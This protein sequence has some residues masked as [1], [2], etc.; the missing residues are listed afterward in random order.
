MSDILPAASAS[1][2]PAAAAKGS[3]GL[4]K[5][6]SR[7]Q[8]EDQRTCLWP[9]RHKARVCKV[10]QRGFN[11]RPPPFFFGTEAVNAVRKTGLQSWQP[12]QTRPGFFKHSSKFHGE[13]SLL[14]LRDGAENRSYLLAPRCHRRR[15]EQSRTGGRRRCSSCGCFSPL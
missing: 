6:G 2:R 12:G 7:P 8:S 3:S 1:Q 4:R 9:T 15:S 13:T 14:R 5:L 11:P 10:T